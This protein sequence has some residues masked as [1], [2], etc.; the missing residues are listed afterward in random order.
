MVGFDCP[1]CY[2][3]NGG[4]FPSMIE[5][6]SVCNSCI[7]N[8]LKLFQN[9]KLGGI[10]E[11]SEWLGWDKRKVSAYLKRGSKKLPLP[12][13]RLK[14]GSIWVFSQFYREKDC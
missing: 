13:A 5:N 7:A 2:C 6:K 12:I 3:Y 1:R 10:A 4:L 8:E 14:C 9:L 11:V